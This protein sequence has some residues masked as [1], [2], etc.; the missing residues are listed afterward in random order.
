MTFNG[1]ALIDAFALYG[2]YANGAAQ[3][4]YEPADD[5]I[6]PGGVGYG[7]VAAAIDAAF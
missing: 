7:A 6:H 3:G 4:F 1:C 2:N 5:L